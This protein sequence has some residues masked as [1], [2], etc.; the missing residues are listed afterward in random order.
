MCD[1]RI[2]KQTHISEVHGCRITPFS[3]PFHNKHTL[4]SEACPQII[5][6]FLSTQICTELDTHISELYVEGG[7]NY[8]FLKNFRKWKQ[9][10]PHVILVRKTFPNM[11]VKFCAPPTDFVVPPS[12]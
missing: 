5:D 11:Y 9:N 4:I 8:R 2:F 6:T 1:Q 10:H 7:D 12:R 3:E